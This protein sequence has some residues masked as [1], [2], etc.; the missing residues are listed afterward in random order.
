MPRTAI[1]APLPGVLSQAGYVLMHD[2]VQDS[3][4][5]DVTNVD[6]QST[7]RF[8]RKRGLRAP[9]TQFNS[10]TLDAEAVVS[11]ALTSIFNPHHVTRSCPDAD[12]SNYEDVHIRSMLRFVN[13]SLQ[14]AHDAHIHLVAS[15]S[16]IGAWNSN[17]GPVIPEAPIE[18]SKVVL[19]QGCGESKH[20]GER[21][22]PEAPRQ[23]GMPTTIKS[24]WPNRW[25][26]NGEG[27]WNPQEWLPTLITTSKAPQ[28]IPKALGSM[29]IDWGPGTGYGF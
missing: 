8:S 21:I 17:N 25:S 6:H 12:A 23:C 24:I 3:G 18:D 2:W 4:G 29:P 28:K 19:P 22:C 14:S 9:L 11:Q 5:F 16:T 1:L 27:M 26:N 20:I 10:T 7:P 13:F 15:V